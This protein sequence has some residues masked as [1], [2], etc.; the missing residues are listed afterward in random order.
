MMPLIACCPVF[1]VTV[2]MLDKKMSLFERRVV[3][4]PLMR[5]ASSL[6]EQMVRKDSD[7]CQRG[8]GVCFSALSWAQG[9]TLHLQF[10]TQM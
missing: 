10:K 5:L 2:K 4:H 9:P 8:V 7:R 1:Q 6:Q 3:R